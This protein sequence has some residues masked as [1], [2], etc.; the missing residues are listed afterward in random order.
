VASVIV[1]PVGKVRSARTRGFRD[2]SRIVTRYDI[3]EPY[4]NRQ[5]H[6]AWF[7]ERRLN[8]LDFVSLPMEIHRGRC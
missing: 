2:A 5:D 6:S 4:G 8:S 7:E 1:M 3:A